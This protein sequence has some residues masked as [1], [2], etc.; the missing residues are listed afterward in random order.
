MS[1]ELEM[2]LNKVAIEE[3]ESEKIDFERRKS[4]FKSVLLKLAKD[5]KMDVLLSAEGRDQHDSEKRDL[6]VLEKAG[7]VK[8][9]TK[10]TH[11][12]EYRQYELTPKGA[13]LVEKL[14]KED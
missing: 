11:R 5:K 3:K 4:S 14:T 13:E 6:D 2:I 12:N 8:G 9:Q 10:Y 7:L 1:L